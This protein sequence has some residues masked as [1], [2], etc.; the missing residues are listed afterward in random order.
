MPEAHL[1]LVGAV[2]PSIRERLTGAGVRI[3]GR[4]DDVGPV[5]DAARVSLAPTRFAAGIPHKVHETVA[6]GLPGVVTPIL[7]AQTGAQVDVA[8]DADGLRISIGMPLA[9]R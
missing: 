2:A 9:H 4:V 8:A 3:L 1:T 6:R 7:A 5:L